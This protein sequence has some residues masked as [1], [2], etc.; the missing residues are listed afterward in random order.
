MKPKNVILLLLLTFTSITIS[1]QDSSAIITFLEGIVD[2]SRDGEY[3]DYNMIDIGTEIENYDL[4]ETGP[5]GYVE[6]KLTTPVSPGVD[7]KIHENTNFYFDSTKSM[8][9]KKTN[10]QVLTGSLTLKVQKLYKD[11]E[12]DVKVN[13]SVMGVRGTEFTVSSTIDGSTLVTTKEGKVACVDSRGNSNYSVPGVVCETEE[14]G[15]FR[16]VKVD[17]S[18]LENYRK[19]W[20]DRR[21]E[22]LKGNALLSIRH[23]AK[24]YR[25]QY[26]QFDKSWEALEKNN[27]IFRKW[28]KYTKEGKKPPLS[29]AVRDKQTVTKAII[30][31]RAILPLFQNNFYVIGE[32][33]KFYR[34]GIGRGS[35]T[36]GDNQEKFFKF[37]QANRRET[38]QRLS[39]SLYYF[40][41]YLAMGKRIS[42][43]DLNTEGLLENLGMGSGMMMGPPKPMKSF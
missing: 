37:F 21:M 18:E 43:S 12:L 24:L 25:E 36:G 19:K 7:L 11:N 28:Q 13:D 17:P 41:I 23:Y 2:I 39:R 30:G 22:V 9:K 3:L 31:L 38:K 35:L 42:G 15:R 10:L 8:G 40:R 32:L 20:N 34:E 16:Q 4:I 6:L 29:E 5:D 33:D 1:A 27:Q 14:K 26:P